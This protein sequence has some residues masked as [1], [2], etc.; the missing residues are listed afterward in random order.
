MRYLS[1]P[2]VHHRTTMVR[3]G[4]L[5]ERVTVFPPIFASGEKEKARKA[6]EES[7]DV[8]LKREKGAHMGAPAGCFGV[9]MAQNRVVPGFIEAPPA[10]TV[11]RK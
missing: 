8:D 3:A 1:S 10:P 2:A 5:V 7:L 4:P 9:E 6:E 11:A